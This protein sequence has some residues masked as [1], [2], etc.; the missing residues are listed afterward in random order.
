MAIAPRHDRPSIHFGK[1][2]PDEQQGALQGSR[3]RCLKGQGK[4]RIAIEQEEDIAALIALAL[5]MPGPDPM[6]PTLVID[7]ILAPFG[8]W[9]RDE[10]NGW[11]HAAAGASRSTVSAARAKRKTVWVKACRA[12]S[13]C[14]V[15]TRADDIKMLSTIIL[16][17]SRRTPLGSRAARPN[18]RLYDG[19]CHI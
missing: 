15:V 19:R 7:E 10:R 8:G 1:S 6:L 13:G 2:D 9:E 4:A 17:G 12:L 14:P 11:S 5:E 16:Q 3:L 18:D